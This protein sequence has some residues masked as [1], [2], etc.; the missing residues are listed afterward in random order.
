ML[1]DGP[2]STG[3]YDSRGPYS[4]ENTTG[5][6]VLTIMSEAVTLGVSKKGNPTS[7]RCCGT[8]IYYMAGLS[9]RSI[10]QNRAF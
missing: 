7:T 4:F 9:K 5:L 3:K 6:D 8:C 2:L 1:S 10:H